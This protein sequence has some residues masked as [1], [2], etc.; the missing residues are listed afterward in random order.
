MA[1][2]QNPFTSIVD[3]IDNI[4]LFGIQ[5]APA[6]NEWV[7]TQ[8]PVWEQRAIIKTLKRCYRLCR[9]EKLHDEMVATQVCLVAEGTITATMAFYICS[10]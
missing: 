5:I 6:L 7:K 2:F 1:I 8:I 3:A 9:H 4:A 10:Y